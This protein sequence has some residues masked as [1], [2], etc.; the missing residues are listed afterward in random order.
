MQ[1]ALWLAIVVD[2]LGVAVAAQTKQNAFVLM[3]LLQVL[4][5]GSGQPQE[6]GRRE[7]AVGA[8]LHQSPLQFLRFQRRKEREVG[9]GMRGR[10]YI[11]AA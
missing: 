2:H 6:G 4:E 3:N 9:G 10:Y 1:Q 7:E 5:V 11:R 8:S